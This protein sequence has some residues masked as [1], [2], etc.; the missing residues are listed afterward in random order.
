MRTSLKVDSAKL[1]GITRTPFPNSTKIYESGRRF[2]DLRVP[3]RQ[4]SLTDT[5][6]A[7]G[8]IEKIED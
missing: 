1:D 5:K 2:P 6:H 8:R 4:I 3:A 7:D